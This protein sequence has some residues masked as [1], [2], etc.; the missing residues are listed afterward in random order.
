[1]R[2][3]KPTSLLYVPAG[4]EVYVR[5]F[6]DY[7]TK[8]KVVYFYRRPPGSETWIAWVEP[9]HGLALFGV[10][11]P[12]T[13]LGFFGGTGNVEPLEQSGSTWNYL[14]YFDLNDMIKLSQRPAQ[15]LRFK[16]AYRGLDGGEA[17]KEAQAYYRC[18]TNHLNDMVEFGPVERRERHE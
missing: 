3:P 1:M 14:N 17:G 12:I 11:A 7:R 5:D 15:R 6:K 9:K 4:K 18:W 16:L 13:V 10:D 8:E 2:F